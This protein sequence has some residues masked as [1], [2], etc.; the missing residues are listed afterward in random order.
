MMNGRITTSTEIESKIV[1]LQKLLKLSTK[2]SVMRIAIGL[3][4]KN[5]SD[6]R[7]KFVVDSNDHSGGTYQIGTITGIYDEVYKALLIEHLGSKIDD[8]KLYQSLLLAHINRGIELLYD[9]YQ[10]K[11]NYDKVIDSIFSLI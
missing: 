9:E 4:L 5:D 2:A 6:P 10:L 8:E 7:K 3:S 1:E 11:G